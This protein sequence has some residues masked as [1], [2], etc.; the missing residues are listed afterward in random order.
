MLLTRSNAFVPVDLKKRIFSK[1][2]RMQFRNGVGI[3]GPPA[4]ED[5]NDQ[6]A[7]DRLQDLAL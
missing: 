5:G 1:A 2:F 7:L 4:N 6:M 3:A